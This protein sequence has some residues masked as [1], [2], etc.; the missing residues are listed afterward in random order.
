MKRWVVA[1]L[2]SP[3]KPHVYID[4]RRLPPRPSL[5]A[6]R[7]RKG[8]EY[9]PSSV[10]TSIERGKGSNNNNN[11]SKSTDA[12]K[13][14]TLENTAVFVTDLPQDTEIRGDEGELKVKMCVRGDGSFNGEAL[15]VFFKEVSATLVG[16]SMDGG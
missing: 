2:L 8:E 10:M 12:C 6:R 3:T 5:L 13:L 7:K 9:D 1:S 4:V 16:N 15:V 11:S 14:Q